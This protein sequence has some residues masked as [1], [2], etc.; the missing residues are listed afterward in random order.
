M[1]VGKVVE[2]NGETIQTIW[3]GPDC[4]NYGGTD[5]TI[6]PPFLTEKDELLSYSPEICR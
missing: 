2:F 6:F 1:D 5:A 4:N 3:G